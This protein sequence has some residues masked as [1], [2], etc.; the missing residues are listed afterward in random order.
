MLL[1]LWSLVWC[2]TRVL[3]GF[4][5]TYDVDVDFMVKE[6][7]KVRQITIDFSK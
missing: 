5:P 3:M 1:C 6:A 2:G 4:Y 7:L